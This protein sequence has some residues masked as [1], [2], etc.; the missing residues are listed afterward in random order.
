M[1]NFEVGTD[2]EYPGVD[3]KT[4]W[5]SR[6]LRIFANL[7]R[8]LTAEEERLFLLIG[9]GHLPIL[10]HSAEASPQFRLVRV[11]DVLGDGR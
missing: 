3:S 8:L 1:G 11:A 2:D 9:S 5:F 7:Q 6:N 4:A 10:L